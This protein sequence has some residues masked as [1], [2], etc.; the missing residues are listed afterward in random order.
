MEIRFPFFYLANVKKDDIISV[1]IKLF[2]HHQDESAPRLHKT[3]YDKETQKKQILRRRIRIFRTQPRD[4]TGDFYRASAY[5]RNFE[6]F[7]FSG[8]GGTCRNVF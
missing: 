6:Y 4:E 5:R 2:R 8:V 3:T 7:K 1:L